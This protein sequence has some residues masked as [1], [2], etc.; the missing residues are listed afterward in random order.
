MLA[1]LKF[2]GALANMF[3]INVTI[4]LYYCQKGGVSIVILEK[5][6]LHHQKA[7]KKLNIRHLNGYLNFS[8]S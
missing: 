5:N 1:M 6:N 4:K 7:S 3:F 8:S 2:L